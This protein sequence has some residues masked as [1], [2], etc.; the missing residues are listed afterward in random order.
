MDRTACVDL[1]AFPLQL[2]LKRR[3]GWAGC[4]VAVLEKD[5]PQGRI[6][7]MNEEARRRGIRTGMGYGAGLSLAGN[8]RGAEVPQE[9][10]AREIES[11]TERLRRFSPQVE[12]S[13]EEPGVFLLSASG[14]DCLYPSLSVWAARIRSGLASIRYRSRVA[15]GFTRFGVYAAARGGVRRGNAVFASSA[16]EKACVRRIPLARLGIGPDLRDRLEALG[17]ETVGAF[18]EL[19]PAGLEERFGPEARALY[20]RARGTA[21]TPLR[22]VPEEVTFMR[23]TLL[24]PPETDCARLL[25]VVKR[26]LDSLLSELKARYEALTGLFLYLDIEALGRR[27]E[28]VRPAEATLDV[29][30][31][32]NL[33]RLRL[34]SLELAGGVETLE[35]IA[36]SH[37]I[38]P[39]QKDLFAC[40]SRRDLASADR[41]LARVRAEFGDDTVL[42]ARLREGHLPEAGFVL[43]RLDYVVFPSEPNSIPASA[44]A[45]D[46][47]IRSGNEAERT[48]VR[49][50]FFR[51]PCLPPPRR[52]DLHGPYVISGGWWRRAVHREYHFARLRSGEILWLYYDRVR[53]RWF[54]QGRV[55]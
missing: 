32:M 49:R 52:A 33:V 43:E 24:E 22:P 7:W 39:E 53:R 6:L 34:E 38:T 5:R 40:G 1:P 47:E 4:P 16:E 44:V 8:L 31:I 26:F 12:P 45:A 30:Q 17:V 42:R 20:D 54:L 46:D 25:F 11:L 18:L 9:E 3:P 36:E 48:M 19:P 14:L 50:I 29:R 37:R 23:R 41:A 55:E 51:S 10:I 13:R 28:R 21:W 35:L 2:L 27:V 15:V